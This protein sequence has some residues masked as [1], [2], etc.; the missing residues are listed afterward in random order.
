MNLFK[1]CWVTSDNE[2]K[3]KEFCRLKSDYIYKDKDNHFVFMAE[4][5]WMLKIM[6]EDWPEIKFHF[7]SEFKMEAAV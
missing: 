3:L 4:T 7:N 5:S 2:A 6:T 1:A